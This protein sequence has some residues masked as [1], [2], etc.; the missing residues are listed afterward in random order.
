MF[1]DSLIN[2]NLMLL[3]AGLAWLIF[4]WLLGSAY[5][6]RIFLSLNFSLVTIW[7]LSSF[8]EPI[9]R[10]AALLF[11]VMLTLSYNIYNSKSISIRIDRML[12]LDVSFVV[13]IFSCVAILQNIESGLTK[14]DDKAIILLEVTNDPNLRYARYIIATSSWMVVQMICSAATQSRWLLRQKIALVA[15]LLASATGLSK[16]SFLPILLTLIFVYGRRLGLLRIVALMSSGFLLTIFLI[17][18]LYVD[19]SFLDITRIFFTRIINNMDVLNYIDELGEDMNPGYPHASP[20]YLLWPF[21]QFT[22][23]NFIVPGIWLHGRLYDDWRGFGPNP[24]F[25]GDLLLASN[26]VGLVMAPIFGILLKFSDKSNYRV[27]IV[28]ICFTFLQDWYSG[29]LYTALYFFIILTMRL[30]LK[31]KR[32]ARRAFIVS[33]K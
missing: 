26:Y 21:Y 30:V 10:M 16:A 31:G 19:I 1:A 8:I 24:T 15:A 3:T 23:N 4:W 22:Q 6:A 33:I 2:S 5:D 9:L 27:F 11:I 18:R 32:F 17:Q 13:I 14:I 28:M 20:Y 25:I 29:C 12:N 7:S